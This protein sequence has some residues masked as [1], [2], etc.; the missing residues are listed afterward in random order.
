MLARSEPHPFQFAPEGEN[1]ALVSGHAFDL[2]ARLPPAMVLAVRNSATVRFCAALSVAP[3]SFIRPD[4]SER[5]TFSADI[6]RNAAS[7]G[8]RV[9]AEAS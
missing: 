5:T 8:A 1:G 3:C 7:A 6:R 9:S 2:D 4:S